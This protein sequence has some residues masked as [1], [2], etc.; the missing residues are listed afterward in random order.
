MVDK[1]A[2]R[3]FWCELCDCPAIKCEKCENSSCNGG[4]CPEC[5]DDFNEVS[6]M[7]AEHT[8]PPKEGLPIHKMPDWF[9]KMGKDDPI[10]E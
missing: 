7:F 5:N 10:E 4:G 6:R 3:W 8:V 2:G 9:W 1:F